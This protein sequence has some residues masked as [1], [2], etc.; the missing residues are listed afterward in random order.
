MS[1]TDLSTEELA[2]LKAALL[3]YKDCRHCEE[4][5]PRTHNEMVRKIIPKIRR[6]A[7]QRFDELT[8]FESQIN[9]VHQETEA[10]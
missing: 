7:A 10:F 1:L 5:A 6:I 4:Y 3:T 8:D 2:L 9:F